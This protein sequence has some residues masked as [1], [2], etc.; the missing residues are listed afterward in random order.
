MDNELMDF[1]PQKNFDFFK[2]RYE[3]QGIAKQTFLQDCQK[4][5]EG[6]HATMLETLKLGVR[7]AELKQKGMWEDV[8]DPQTG[9]TFFHSS[10]EKFSEYAFGFGKTR[11]S[12]L[13]S[14]AEFAQIDE[15]TGQLVYKNSRYIGMNMSQLV[16]LAPLSEWQREYYTSKISVADMRICKRYQNSGAFF[17][18]KD[19]EGFDLLSSAKAWTEKLQER[20]EQEEAEQID[21]EL[22]AAAEG[23]AEDETFFGF[24]VPTSE[25]KDCLDENSD[26]G[27]LNDRKYSFASRTS[28]RKFLADFESWEQLGSNEF[29]DSIRV[30]GF[31][32]GMGLYAATCKMCVTATWLEEKEMLFF[33]LY[34]GK[35]NQPIKISKQKLEI[36]LKAHERELL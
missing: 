23:T 27:I 5:L 26:V 16:E 35:G 3:P 34:V 14:L 29:F 2:Y 17:D 7:L 24:T 30:F 28:V 33:F 22:D 19:K 12:N 11:T 20:K 18:E 31:K 21:R 6:A 9:K 32:N 4:V 1:T 15:T 8:I 36:W 13:L 10:F 25:L